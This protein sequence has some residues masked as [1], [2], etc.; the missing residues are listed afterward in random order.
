MTIFKLAGF[1][2]ATPRISKKL[3]ADQNAQSAINTKL[4]NGELKS[5]LKT[6][7]LSPKVQFNFDPKV[8]FK[9]ADNEWIADADEYKVVEAPINQASGYV[10]L[11]NR[12]GAN[13]TYVQAATETQLNGL[14]TFPTFPKSLAD[15]QPLNCPAPD[16]PLTVSVSGSGSGSSEAV[17]YVYT[18]VCQLGDVELES[19]PSAASNIVNIHSGH[20]VTLGNAVDPPDFHSLSPTYTYEEYNVTKIRVYRSA[21]GDSSRNY[22][23]L[24][25][26]NV[27][28]TTTTTNL[29][30]ETIPT[31]ELGEV[32]PSLDWNIPPATN[33]AFHDIAVMPNGIL[34]GA[35]GTTLYFSEPYQPQAFPDEYTLS[36]DSPIV[37]LGVY[38]SSLVVATE[39]NPFIASGIDPANMSLEKMPV[40][41]PCLSRRSIV[42]DLTGVVYASPNG[43]IRVSNSGAEN[44][45][46]GIFT[47]E[48]WS[49]Y[50]P[51]NMHGAFGNGKY[52]LFTVK[53]TGE[54]VGLIFDSY[55]P[56]SPMSETNVHATA[57]F[58][59][60]KNSVLYLMVN[61]E[62][63]DW[64]TTESDNLNY[65][66]KSKMF[67]APYPINL[68][69]A[70]VDADYGNIEFTTQQIAFL[71]QLKTENQATTTATSEFEGEVNDHMLNEFTLNGSILNN[72]PKAPQ[73]GFVLLQIYADEVLKDSIYFSN[74]E[75]VRLKSGYKTDRWEFIVA[76][77][78]PLRSVKLAETF[79]ELKQI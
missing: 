38:G 47:K 25:E 41:E 64:D 59:D 43:I 74:Q 9:T 8:L 13:G 1:S 21:A 48:Q 14:P 3:I 63:K 23:F 60:S 20:T 68:G 26:V 42:S 57:T 44:I 76:G 65:E 4:D 62:V 69:A 15:T 27:V 75:S 22:L 12:Q 61:K 10:L 46:R 16:A 34:V 32:L 28:Q 71:E 51:A 31:A 29:G 18:F 79:Q 40:N 33:G 39:K 5:W 72:L 73:Q 11:I 67:D 77:N 70:V 53:V 35:Q 24:K 54:K 17:V 36:V 78:V 52:F 7:S 19:P 55:N 2:G 30:T 66:W 58:F 6:G 49:E 45:S 37:G 56:V 50:A